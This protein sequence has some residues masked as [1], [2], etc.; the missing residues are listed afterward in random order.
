MEYF[1][2]ILLFTRK[3]HFPKNLSSVITKN[4]SKSIE[5]YGRAEPR[6]IKAH[7][8]IDHSGILILTHIDCLFHPLSN[9]SVNEKLTSTFESKSKFW[10]G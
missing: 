2:F 3:I 5:R 8:S 4:V 6:G 10:F 7:F 9:D 1:Y